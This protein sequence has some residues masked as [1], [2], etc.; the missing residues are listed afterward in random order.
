MDTNNFEQLIK[1]FYWMEQQDSVS[2]CLNVGQYKTQIFQTREQ[3]GFEGNGYDRT[4]LAS[5]FLEEQTPELQ[6]EI[7]FD[8]KA[9]KVLN[10]YYV[11]Q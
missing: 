10:G 5:V 9:R 8:F 6:G 4:S 11:K 7:E 3:E 2:V 1:P